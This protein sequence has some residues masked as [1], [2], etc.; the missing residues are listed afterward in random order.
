MSTVMDSGEEIGAI[1][2]IRRGVHFSPELKEGIRGTRALAVL[3]SAGPVVVPIAVQQ[4]LD[5]GVN[6]PGGPDV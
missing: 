2:T 5:R 1:R 4:V 3:A 6:G